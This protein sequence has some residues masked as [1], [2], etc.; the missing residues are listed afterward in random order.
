MKRANDEG[1]GRE[2]SPPV[3][4]AY[5]RALKAQHLTVDD[6]IRRLRA[7]RS[8]TE[9]L[10][11]TAARIWGES[12]PYID[13]GEFE[14]LLKV[15]MMDLENEGIPSEYAADLASEAEAGHTTAMLGFFALAA[16]S[17]SGDHA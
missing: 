10:H 6:L 15:G 14:P 16:E 9:P 4:L 11:V 5:R 12:L 13:L 8:A 7:E 2:P 3:D 1:T 17:L